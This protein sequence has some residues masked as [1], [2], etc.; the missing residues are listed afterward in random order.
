MKLKFK[1]QAYQTDATSAAV[2]LF[3]GQ[4]KI[5]STFTVMEERQLSLLQ[6]EYGYGN[7]LLIDH[8]K[9]LENMQEVQ[10]RFNLPLTNDI[11][12]KRFCIDMETATG[13]TFVYTQTI[14]ELNR[15]YGFTKFIVVVPSVAIREGVKKSLDATK[16]YFSQ[17]YDNIPSR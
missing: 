1:K 10:R 8:K 11:E 13:K 15:R 14:L 5:A 2:N 16:E 4:E 3:A 9:M 17:A 7:A 12:D 6:N